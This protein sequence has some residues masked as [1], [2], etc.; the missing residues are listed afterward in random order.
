M[1]TYVQRPPITVAAKWTGDNE[2][3][4]HEAVDTVTAP[5]YWGTQF[6][7]DEGGNGFIQAFSEELLPVSI[8]QWV[9][10]GGYES[11]AVMDDA[12]FAAI[13]QTGTG[14]VASP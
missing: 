9:I 6:S 1:G 5:D 13:Y 10:R 4:M 8:G 3:E 7:V 11:D 2:A 14:F 12:T